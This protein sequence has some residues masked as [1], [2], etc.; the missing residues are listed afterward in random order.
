MSPRH[1][2]AFAAKDRLAGI[3]AVRD[4]HP[5]LREL[6]DE[7]RVHDGSISSMFGLVGPDN[8]LVPDAQQVSVFDLDLVERVLRDSA[9][10]S[11]SAYA[12]SL[13]PIIGRTIL[14]MDPP[15]HQRYRSLLQGAFTKKEMQRWE[16][17]FVGDI[18]R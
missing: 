2:D 16:H 13:R 6:R 10:F 12:P 18:V 5:R 1:D 15:E 14:E 11:S 17:D 9:T 4:P 7:R 3:G 8:F